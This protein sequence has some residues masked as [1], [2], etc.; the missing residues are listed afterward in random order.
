MYESQSLS[1]ELQWAIWNERLNKVESNIRELRLISCAVA[2]IILVLVTILRASDFYIVVSLAASG[3]L[4]GMAFVYSVLFLGRGSMSIDFRDIGRD[5]HDEGFYMLIKE[6]EHTFY[7][8][9]RRL[10]ILRKLAAMS[11]IYTIFGI[12][13]FLYGVVV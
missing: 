6:L 7:E 10:N 5:L 3:I 12:F 2:I 9:S 4:W 8:S 1:T 11:M 13:G